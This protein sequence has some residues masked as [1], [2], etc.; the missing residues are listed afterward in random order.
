MVPVLTLAL[1]SCTDSPTVA[2]E[3]PTT[4]GRLSLE[5]QVVVEDLVL[6]SVTCIGPGNV[7]SPV[8][9]QLGVDVLEV[10]FD[11]GPRVDLR[12]PPI[13]VETVR[14]VSVFTNDVGRS[15]RMEIFL[16]FPSFIEPTCIF[17]RGR[18]YQLVR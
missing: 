12:C 10:S 17:L 7:R 15:W 8:Y 13:G 2:K 18:R 14:H 4:V 3:Q 5:D 1:T 11:E 6:I 16:N 9:P